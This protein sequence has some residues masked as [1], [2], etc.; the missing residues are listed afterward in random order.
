MRYKNPIVKIYYYSR[1]LIRSGSAGE[2]HPHTPTDPCVNPLIH[3]AP[4][5]L[6]YNIV[7]CDS[8][9]NSA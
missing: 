5:S 9:S 2:F 7:Y 1:I 8:S 6:T 4:A 3:T